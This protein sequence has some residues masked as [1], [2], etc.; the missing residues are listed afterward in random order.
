MKSFLMF[1]LATFCCMG[2]LASNFDVDGIHYEMT[3]NTT[4]GVTFSSDKSNNYEGLTS[5]VIPENVT[6]EGVTYNVT[7]IGSNAFMYCKS[8]ESVVIPNTIDSIG[9]Q[10]FRGCTSLTK[11][12]IPSSVKLMRESAFAGCESLE[13]VCLKASL[14]EIEAETFSHCTLLKS[15]VIP[16]GVES[17]GHHAFYMCEHLTSVTM[18]S[19]LKFIG[20]SAFHS[21][22]SLPSATIGNGVDIISKCAFSNCESLRTLVIPG[23]VDSIGYQAFINCPLKEIYAFALPK[24]D[25]DVF[26][27]SIPQ[28]AT[29]Y[30]QPGL[31]PK[32]YPWY[33]F[34]T[35]VEI[36]AGIDDILGDDETSADAPVYN[37]QGVRMQN[38]DNLPRG[39]YIK[40][41]KKFLVQ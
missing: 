29:L 10:A 3:S 17:V 37:I 15:I 27:A 23:S 5:L 31:S 33:L 20:E 22:Y 35:V 40:G 14:K 19:S 11:V 12:K 21:C 28:Q 4:V 9:S 26:S 18:P 2:A 7:S 32:H 30:V 13:S 16:K 38:A 1:F 24:C 8:L 34:K 25:W 39:V 6:Y 36:P 41:K